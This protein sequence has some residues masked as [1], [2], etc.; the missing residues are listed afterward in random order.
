MSLP[1]ETNHQS[2][3]FLPFNTTKVFRTSSVAPTILWQQ[4][5][6]LNWGLSDE[7]LGLI[8]ASKEKGD[9][10]GMHVLKEQDLDPYCLSTFV[11]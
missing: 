5:A 1:S 4:W 3:K 6:C 2:V 10:S 7:Q 8:L 11:A 9:L